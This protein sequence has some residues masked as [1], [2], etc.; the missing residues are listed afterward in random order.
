MGRFHYVMRAQ[1]GIQVPSIPWLTPLL[2][3]PF[4]S[5]TKRSRRNLQAIVAHPAGSHSLWRDIEALFI[6]LGADMCARAG[7]RVALVRVGAV[8]SSR[9]WLEPHGVVP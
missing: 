3:V 5:G 9:H 6:E 8:T 7:S 4:L 2:V 1:A